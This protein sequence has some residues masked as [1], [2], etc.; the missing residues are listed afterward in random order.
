MCFVDGSFLFFV[1]PYF[2]F[3]VLEK[4][5]EIGQISRCGLKI[6]IKGIDRYFLDANVFIA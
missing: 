6:S 1:F 3:L 5:D 2:D 4:S